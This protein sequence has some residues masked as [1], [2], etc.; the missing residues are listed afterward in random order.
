M[1]A[2]WVDARRSAARDRI[3]DVAG[4]VF[5]EHG[6]DVSM[7]DIAAAAGCSR[8]TLYRHFDSRTALQLGYIEKTAHTIAAT[9]GDRTAHLRDGPD[10]VTESVLVAL[11][12]VRADPALASWFAP[13]NAGTTSGLALASAAVDAV[14]RAFVGDRPDAAAAAQWLTRVIVSLLVVPDDDERATVER[15]VTPVVS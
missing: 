10:K 13:D 11:A 1:S 15:F 8:A 2:D 6:P 14:T 12:E 3:V 7:A 5:A 9:I 4:T